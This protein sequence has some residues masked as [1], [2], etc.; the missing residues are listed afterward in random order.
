MKTKLFIFAMLASVATSATVKVT[1]VSTD[2]ANSKVTFKVE[3]SSTPYNNRTWVWID[4]CPINGT[5]P[6]NSFS[7]ATISNAT[8]NNGNGTVIYSSTNT[9]GFFVE[10][11]S[12]TNAGTTVT[13]TLSNAPAGKFNWCAYGSDYPPNVTVNGGTYTFRGTPPFILKDANGNITQTIA[14][15]TLLT[16][17]LITA[18]VPAILTDQTGYPGVFCIY[19]GSDLYIDATHLCQQRTSGAKNWEAWI[20]DMRD[21][22]LYRIVFMP[23]NKWWLAQN[24]KYAGTGYAI[25]GCTKD[26][27]GRAYTYAQ[28]YTSYD[29]GTSGSTGNV[30]GVCPSK[31]LLPVEKDWTDFATSFG[32]SDAVICERLR[33][34]T[35]N[36][37]PITDYYGWALKISVIDGVSVNACQNFYVNAWSGARH[38]GFGVDGQYG[39]CSCNILP[40]RTQPGSATALTHIRCFRTL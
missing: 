37:S 31:W 33:A 32:V 15:K 6:S 20:K 38:W 40:S 39:S 8:K 10:H 7:T 21:N 25:S 22:E 12:A 36:C 4:F 1:P 19:I 26:E 29:G 23:D 16:A 14:G 18:P 5:T 24:V 17:N 13:A 27:C 11:A 34:H 2:Y 3:W 30:Q 28:A 9:R 35:S